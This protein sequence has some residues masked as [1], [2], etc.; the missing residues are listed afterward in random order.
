MSISRCACG[1][2]MQ[3]TASRKVLSMVCYAGRVQDQH[4]EVRCHSNQ[5]QHAS[6]QQKG[7]SISR[8][9]AA[10]QQQWDHAANAHLGPIDITPM[11]G[12]KVWWVCDQCPDGHLHR[13]EAIVSNRSNGRGCPQCSGR[14]VCKHN[15]LATKAPLA[16]A[17]WD[18]EANNG[19][20]DS[21]VAQSNQPVGWLCDA[22]GHKWRATPNTRVRHRTGCPQCANAD[23]KGRKK[24]KQP[25]FAECKDPEV[26]ALLA[27][28][29]HSR[30]AEHG[31][32]PDKVT[33]Q[34][35][36]QIFWLCTNC[37]AGQQHSWPAQ[38][39]QRTDRNKSGCPYCA[40]R[41]TCR[42]NSLQALHPDIAAEWDHAKNQGQLSDYTASSHHVAWWF[43]PQRGSWQQAIDMRTDHRLKRNQ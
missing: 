33:L 28:W 26:R 35:H 29:D 6:I 34:S 5:G 43:S 22:C 11:S 13:W 20:P 42:C 2:V 36:K 37:P 31:H 41:A 19:T 4:L 27:Q 12:R 1:C 38:P 21:V 32:F 16:A 40:G 9:D 30:N 18:Y 10:L 23:A 17:Q 8:L 25:T 24:I 39:Y 14:K 15:S 3:I 7:P